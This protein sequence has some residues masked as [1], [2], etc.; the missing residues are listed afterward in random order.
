MLP[1][2]TCMLDGE[3]PLFHYTTNILAGKTPCLMTN[4]MRH[5]HTLNLHNRTWN[6]K[7]CVWNII[8]QTW[9]GHGHFRS[10]LCSILDFSPV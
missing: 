4:I 6:R 5:I 1:S 8:F 10:F 2:P 7:K 3:I 9:T